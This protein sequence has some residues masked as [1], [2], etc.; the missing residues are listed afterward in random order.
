MI[1]FVAFLTV[2]VPVE[3]YLWAQLFCFPVILLKIL[4]VNRRCVRNM[5]NGWNKRL[6]L[7][8][9]H[10]SKSTYSTILSPHL[11]FPSSQVFTVD[12]RRKSP[13]LVGNLARIVLPMNPLCTKWRARGQVVCLL[14]IKPFDQSPFSSAHVVLWAPPVCSV[15][16]RTLLVQKCSQCDVLPP[17]KKLISVL[18]LLS[19][20]K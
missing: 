3:K 14:L 17:V 1:C 16:Q 20:L 19:V 13:F 5:C 2:N 9:A 11:L 6:P 10:K 12:V 4:Y 15:R 18:M 7:W 8:T